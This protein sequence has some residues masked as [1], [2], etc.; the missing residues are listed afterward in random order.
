MV[1]TSL[2]RNQV[3]HPGTWVRIPPSPLFRNLQKGI[4]NADF[5]VIVA[6]FFI[7]MLIFIGIM[8]LILK[9]QSFG[10]HGVKGTYK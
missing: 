10:R 3:V 1:V 8:S 4:R 7:V 5:Y 9:Q 6:C 2:T